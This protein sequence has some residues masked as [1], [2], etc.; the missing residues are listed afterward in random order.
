MK[1]TLPVKFKAS[2]DAL[3]FYIHIKTKSTIKLINY[4]MQATA[5]NDKWSSGPNHVKMK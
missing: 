2:S 5:R 1:K 4:N 3:A